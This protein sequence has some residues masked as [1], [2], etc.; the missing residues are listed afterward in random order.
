MEVFKIFIKDNLYSPTSQQLIWCAE[1]L[2]GTSL[3]EVDLN[4]LQENTFAHIQK[5][6]LLR[7]GL[8]GSGTKS[9]YEVYGGI[10]KIVGQMI[11][12]SYVTDDQQYDLMGQPLMY[13]DAITYYNA[14]YL[15]DPGVQNSGVN[16]ITQF[17]FGFKQKLNI[18]GVN[19]NFKAIAQFPLNQGVQVELTIVSDTDLNGR[20]VIRRNNVVVDE[21]EAPLVKSVGGEI[22]WIMR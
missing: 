12:V 1:Y 11:Q 7:F 18:N 3:C 19:F 15:F 2:D 5:D 10:F 13:K 20:L 8:F 17:N 14:E 6:N 21:F 22:T 16:R 4:T 9:Y